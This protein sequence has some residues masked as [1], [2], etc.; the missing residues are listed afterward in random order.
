MI[1]RAVFTKGTFV[2]IP[3]LRGRRKKVV[4]SNNDSL[5]TASVP[6]FPALFMLPDPHHSVTSSHVA[7]RSLDNHCLEEADL[8]YSPDVTLSRFIIITRPPS[9][10]SLEIRHLTRDG[11]PPRSSPSNVAPGQSAAPNQDRRQRKGA[12]T[13]ASG[14]R[15]P[16]S[17]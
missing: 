4:I 14:Q 15:Q 10:S 6:R 2:C 3:N 1:G 7:R 8:D 16:A 13:R 9:E 17:V 12:T 5:V 11:R